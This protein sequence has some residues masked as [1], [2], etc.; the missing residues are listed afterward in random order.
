MSMLATLVVAGAALFGL[1]GPSSADV[2]A[3]EGSAFGYT[4]SV[5]LFGGPPNVRGVGQFVC[6]SESP[7]PALP[8]GCVPAAQEAA[9]ASAS[10]TLPATG[11]NRS[12]P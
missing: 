5:S 1:S 9:A 12:Q 6:T 2:T 11:G 4:M 10:V 8:P 3:V 7:P